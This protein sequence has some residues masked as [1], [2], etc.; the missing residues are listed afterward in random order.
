VKCFAPSQHQPITA[1]N[2][3]EDK[4]VTLRKRIVKLATTIHEVS[5]LLAQ[6]LPFLVV[7]S[8]W[9]ALTNRLCGL[10]LCPNSLP[11]ILVV[12]S[13]TI[14][15]TLGAMPFSWQGLF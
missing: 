8:R 9:A 14:T 11:P 6:D 10:I 5:R 3:P 13:R 2:N 7:I 15:L 1:L 12:P 4:A